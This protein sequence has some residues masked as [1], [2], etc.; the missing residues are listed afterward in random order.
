MLCA[1]K[2]VT[3]VGGSDAHREHPY[4]RHGNPTTHV[5]AKSRTVGHILSA[6][7]EGCVTMSCCPDGPR[8]ELRA[9]D[10]IM[11]GTSRQRSFDIVLTA[12]EPGDQVVL[13]SETGEVKR[14]TVLQSGDFAAR[15]EHEAH[16]FLRAELWRH[17]PQVNG[18]LMAA[19]TNPVFMHE[20]AT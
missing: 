9:P 2:R 4:V 11:G 16:K 17:F 14:Y 8:L 6:I 12:A 10:A 7:H 13:L 3:G 5:Y 15:G 19:L 18:Q 20:A 1:G